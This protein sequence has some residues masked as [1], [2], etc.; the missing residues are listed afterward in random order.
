VHSIQ[1]LGHWSLRHLLVLGWV[2]GGGLATPKV[3]KLWHTAPAQR[4]VFVERRSQSPGQWAT[5]HSTSQNVWTIPLNLSHSCFTVAL[6]CYGN[7]ACTLLGKDIS[8]L[9]IFAG[10]NTFPLMLSLTCAVVIYLSASPLLFETY[11]M[12][13]GI[14][15]SIELME[16]GSGVSQAFSRVLELWDQQNTSPFAMS[17]DKAI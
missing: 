1:H 16:Q 7:V 9:C 12:L 5:Y 11:R 14:L 8:K 3:E 13:L 4:V 2:E 6:G 10:K 17:S 15:S